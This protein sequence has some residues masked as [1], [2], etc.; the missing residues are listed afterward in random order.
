M[1]CS[2]ASIGHADIMWSIVP[3]IIIIIIIIIITTKELVFF[4]QMQYFFCKV[5]I[6]IS[7][8]SFF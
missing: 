8:L 5:E 1:Y 2:F 3:S 7:L 4:D 6:T